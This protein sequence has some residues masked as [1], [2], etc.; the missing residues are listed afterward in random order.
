MFTENEAKQ[1]WCPFARISTH[2][3]TAKNRYPFDTDYSEKKSFAC[4]IASDCMAWR[5][6][7][8]DVRVAEAWDIVPNDFLL[9]IKMYRAATGSSLADSKHWADA[10]K[11]GD[12][13][14]PADS[15]R[16]FCGLAGKP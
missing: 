2:S 4:C 10:V 1:R 6:V 7:P 16:G 13:L 5:R 12:E 11:R 14:R 8:V 3:D 15:E 9:G